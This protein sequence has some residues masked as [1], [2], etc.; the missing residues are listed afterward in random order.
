MKRRD[1][2]VLF[3]AAAVWPMA[4]RAQQTAIPVVAMLNAQSAED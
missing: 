3:G 1:A 4:A 2:L